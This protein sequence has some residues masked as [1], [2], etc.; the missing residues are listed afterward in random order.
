MNQLFKILTGSRLYGTFTDTSDYDYKVITLPPLEDVLLGK[1][2]VNYKEVPEGKGA[3]D[4]MPDN[5][6]ETEYIPLQ[7]FFNDFFAGQ[8]YAVELA[9]AILQGKYDSQY[10]YQSTIDKILY[11]LE[12]LNKD[13]LLCDHTQ[14]IE[15]IKK[16]E[17]VRFSEEEYHS[18]SFDINLIRPVFTIA[19][20]TEP[21]KFRTEV[22]MLK[23]HLNNLK[24]GDYSEIYFLTEMIQDLVE[25]FLTKDVKKMMGYAVSQAKVYG[26]KTDRYVTVVSAIDILSSENGKCILNEMPKLIEALLKLPFTNI[27]STEVNNV[28]NNTIVINHK[29][30]PLS[31]Q[32]DYIVNSL[33]ATEH[34]YG[35][36]VKSFQ[37]TG[38]DWKAMAHAVR[39]VKQIQEL[40]TTG[41]ILFPSKDIDQIKSIRNGLMEVE[42]ATNLL[43]DSIVKAEE[44]IMN[45]ILPAKTPEMIE[46]FNHW[47]INVLKSLYYI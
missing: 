16:I 37:G 10:N 28:V 43:N 7:V 29:Q 4:S 9:F 13:D 17:G 6:I 20:F 42:D 22:G 33:K 2:L 18:D 5:G 21:I 34:T 38:A 19:P 26:A 12:N 3:H 30:Y 46:M 35:D 25:N 44:S 27:N 47:K 39:I 36:R 14:A 32:L 40:S 8:T 45:S 41:T 23:Y 31:C 1:K 24:C 11:I 15:E